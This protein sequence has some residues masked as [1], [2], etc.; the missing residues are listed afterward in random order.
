MSLGAFQLR[1]GTL[2]RNFQWSILFVYAL[3]VRRIHIVFVDRL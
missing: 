3:G 2:Q 1:Y